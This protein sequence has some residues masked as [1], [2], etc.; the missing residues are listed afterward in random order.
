M[1]EGQENVPNQAPQA[2]GTPTNAVMVQPAPARNLQD[3]LRYSAEVSAAAGGPSQQNFQ[4]MDEE[5]CF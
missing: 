1:S 5:V 2:V 3:M 4:P